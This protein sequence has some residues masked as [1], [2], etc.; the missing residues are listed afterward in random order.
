MIKAHPGVIDVLVVGVP[1]ERFG[2]AVTAVVEADGSVDTQEIR[3]F[4]ESRLA[5]Y[6]AP[7]RVVVVEK[8]PRAP[9]GKPDYKTALDL[10]ITS[11]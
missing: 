3:A 11:A 4:T 2:S 10:A 1:D 9:S 8:V 7:R 5:G 6:K